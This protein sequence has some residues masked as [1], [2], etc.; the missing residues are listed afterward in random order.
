M[1]TDLPKHAIQLLLSDTER[2]AVLSRA[3]AAAGAAE[4]H[5]AFFHASRWDMASEIFHRLTAHL[6]DITIA[7]DDAEQRDHAPSGSAFHPASRHI[8]EVSRDAARTLAHA[9]KG[10]VAE[11]TV[12]VEEAGRVRS[13][14]ARGHHAAQEPE[15]S[16]LEVLI[17]F[18]HQLGAAR[19]R[20]NALQSQNRQIL[21]ELALDEQLRKRAANRHE[22]VALEAIDLQLREDFFDLIADLSEGAPHPVPGYD[23]RDQPVTA[24]LPDGRPVVFFPR[25][26][27]VTGHADF[28]PPPLPALGLPEVH[29]L[30]GLARRHFPRAAVVVVANGRF[31]ATAQRYAESHDMQF[32]GREGLERWAT[33]C[34]P[35]QTVLGSCEAHTNTETVQ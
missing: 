7:R 11:A 8:Q 28:R 20:V 22:G 23:G 27:P 1:T 31:S 33:W 32:I 14:I 34:S 35:L 3:V 30:S 10:E 15:P 6:D 5:A 2:D 21:H 13:Q 26:L 16:L 9:L 29:H 25:H 24:S 17:S 18:Q 12:A 19:T 4:L